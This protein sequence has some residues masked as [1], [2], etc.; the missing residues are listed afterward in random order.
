M[1]DTI[2]RN[3]IA[4]E[5]R[6]IEST[7]GCPQGYF[8]CGCGKIEHFD[9]AQPASEFPWADLICNECFNEMTEKFEGV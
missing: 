7:R 3:M 4:A 2:E 1:M 5:N 6:F 8:R 9:N